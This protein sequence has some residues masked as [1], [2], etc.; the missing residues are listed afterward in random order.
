MSGGGRTQMSPQSA[1]RVGVSTTPE[2]SAM[3]MLRTAARLTVLL[4]LVAGPAAAQSPGPPG[5]APQVPPARTAPPP[6]AAEPVP[7]QP[8]APA[9]SSAAEPPAA[10]DIPATDAPMADAPAVDAPTPVLPERTG[11][12]GLRRVPNAPPP[13]PERSFE[14]KQVAVLQG[15]DKIT[16][17]TSTFTVPVGGSNRFGQLDITV[18]ACRKAPPIDPPESAAF[19]EIVE[20][21]QGEDERRH[22]SG[23]MFASSPALSAMEHA[24]YD[25]WVKDCRNESTSAP[26]SS[27]Q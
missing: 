10:T 21:K 7:A 20:R 12:T 25:V 27:A 4:A 14:E 18:R 24:V 6:P 9:P 2:P 1:G 11:I 16:A 23:W 13:A 22:F 26:S 5:P 15:L 3:P 17:R 8:A 19:L